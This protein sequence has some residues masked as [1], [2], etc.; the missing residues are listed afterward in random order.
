MSDGFVRTIRVIIGPAV[1]AGGTLAAGLFAFQTL[2][3]PIVHPKGI[4]RPDTQMEPTEKFEPLTVS[5]LSAYAE[6]LRRP[7]FSPARRAAPVQQPGE[8]P[9]AQLKDI[10][11]QG[12]VIDSGK[13]S[14]VIFLPME[15]DAA[16]Y[17]VGAEVADWTIK[18]IEAREVTLTRGDETARLALNYTA[19]SSNSAN[20]RTADS[21]LSPAARRARRQT[22][23]RVNAASLIDGMENE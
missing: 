7:L 2:R 3:A 6:T 13:P 18:D 5:T 4:V 19:A 20:S 23:G 11:L 22:K 15:G 17:E 10:Q 12:I 14:A 1:L 16:A 8:A 21:S 9:T